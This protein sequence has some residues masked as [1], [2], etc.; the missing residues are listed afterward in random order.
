MAIKHCNE[1]K[2]YPYDACRI[3]KDSNTSRAIEYFD[4]NVLYFIN[5]YRHKVIVN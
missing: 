3:R 5:N 1:F 4:D 2:W